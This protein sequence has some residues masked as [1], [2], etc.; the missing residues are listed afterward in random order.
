VEQFSVVEI[1][2]L[3]DIKLV[4]DLAHGPLLLLGLGFELR[5]SLEVPVN[6]EALFGFREVFEVEIE[7]V[8]QLLGVL[9]FIV[10]LGRSRSECFKFLDFFKER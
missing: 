1:V 2:S 9:R 4:L 7:V 5:F 6:Q 3:A 8:S 10:R